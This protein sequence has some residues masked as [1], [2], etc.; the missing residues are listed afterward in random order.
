MLRILIADDHEVARRGIRAMLDVLDRLR[1][2]LHILEMIEEI[3]QGLGR[4]SHT[5]NLEAGV[6]L[7]LGAWDLEL[8]IG[9]RGSSHLRVNS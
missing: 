2:V 9:V 4:L 5:G 7:E 8:L 1:L 6:S 3:D